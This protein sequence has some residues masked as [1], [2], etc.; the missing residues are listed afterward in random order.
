MR[1]PST[2]CGAKTKRPFLVAVLGVAAAACGNESYAPDL[3]LPGLS[4]PVVNEWTE[5]STWVILPVRTYGAVD[6]PLAF[7]SV[8]GAAFLADGVLAVADRQ[9]CAVLLIR[10]STSRLMDR[11]GR[12]GS[13][14]GEFQQIAS[15]TTFEDTL[16]L[17]DQ[18]SNALVV[19]DRDGHEVRRVGVSVSSRDGLEEMDAADES[20]LVVTWPGVWTSVDASRRQLGMVGLLD[21][22]TG[23]IRDTLIYE[24]P[25]GVL[26]GGRYIR[27]KAAC[28]ADIQGRSHVLA[29]NDWSF[30]GVAIDLDS[31]TER[32]HFVT[33]AELEPRAIESGMWIPG[34]IVADVTCAGSGALFKLSR[35]PNATPAVIAETYL[36]MRSY[37][38]SVL[39]RRTVR[40]DSSLLHGRFMDSRGDTILVVSHTRREYPVVAEFVLV[41]RANA[42]LRNI[43]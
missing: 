23:A 30:E 5:D 4:D 32:F 22:R 42:R 43:P 35:T 33:D 38:G 15:M 24:V 17:Y 6:G 9:S 8:V 37:D 41:E 27:H 14:P 1:R 26:D 13:G 21:S 36:E 2:A 25:R 11:L 29:M 31:R 28:A 12:C 39:L 3:L 10:R 16:I 18:G 40:S 7:G 20:T 19:V 34:G